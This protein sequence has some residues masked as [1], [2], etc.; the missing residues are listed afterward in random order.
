MAQLQPDSSWL[1]ESSTPLEGGTPAAVSA[2][3]PAP[4]A[5][6]LDPV[7]QSW[8]DDPQFA[9]LPASVQSRTVANYAQE[10]FSAQ[11]G[12]KELPPP[13]QQAAIQNF[14]ATHLEGG[15]TLRLPVTSAVRAGAQPQTRSDQALRVPLAQDTPPQDVSDNP[16][17]F[18]DTSPAAPA[19]RPGPGRRCGRG[20]G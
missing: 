8:K 12:F 20:R 1:Q 11:P 16:N 17:P 18:Q 14:V 19:P 9:T 5:P 4:S 7:I 10:Q 6:Q 13:V 3:A 2:Q 15:S